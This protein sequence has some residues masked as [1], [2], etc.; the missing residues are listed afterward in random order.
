[1]ISP[2]DFT[3]G[4]A[5]FL[6]LYGFGLWLWSWTRV[7]SPVIRLRYQDCGVVIVFASTLA[8]YAVRERELNFLDW[9]LVFLG[10]LF[11]GSALWRL[12]RTQSFIK[13]D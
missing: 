8:L 1:M 11:V 13:P 3:I 6:T 4:L 10:P 12:F 7:S 9:F 5:W 2:A